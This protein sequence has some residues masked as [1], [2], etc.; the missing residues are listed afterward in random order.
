MQLEGN[1]LASS[2][3]A[4]S[5]LPLIHCAFKHIVGKRHESQSQV[6]VVNCQCQAV[7][8]TTGPARVSAPCRC[9]KSAA[10]SPT[11]STG[12]ALPLVKGFLLRE[13]AWVFI[14]QK[15]QEDLNPYSS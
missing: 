11:Q 1:V 4:L 2:M 15:I 10:G 7:P 12:E 9:C 14:F 13:A 6:R 3:Q 5:L 8:E